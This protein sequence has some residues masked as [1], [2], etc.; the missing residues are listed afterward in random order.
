MT[1]VKTGASSFAVIKDSH[2]E[3][4]LPKSEEFKIENDT[5]SEEAL[6]QL[7][8]PIDMRLLLNPTI[9]LFRYKYL[10]NDRVKSAISIE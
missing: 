9:R 7:L 2:K 6:E 3:I 5:V 10:Y 1:D 8:P 4:K